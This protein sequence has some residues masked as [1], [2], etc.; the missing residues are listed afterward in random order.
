VSD[1]SVE[2]V[3]HLAR[4]VAD[5]L[6]PEVRCSREQLVAAD[7]SGQSLRTRLNEILNPKPKV[8]DKT[9]NTVEQQ[10][11]PHRAQSWLDWLREHVC[12]TLDLPAGTNANA[13]TVVSSARKLE[14]SEVSK[15]LAQVK[16]FSD[17]TGGPRNARVS[18]T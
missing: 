7:I 13:H 5:K 3:R 11:K 18:E 4:E 12:G 10:S 14:K 9:H 16:A 1:L 8:L 6:T 17:P 2:G 15:L